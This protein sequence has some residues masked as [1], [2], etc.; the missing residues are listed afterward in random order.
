M[1]ALKDESE[2]VVQYE[3]DPDLHDTEQAP[4]TEAGGVAAFLR[5][6]VLPYYPDG[7]VRAGDRQDRLRDQL[8]PLLLPTPAT[9]PAGGDQG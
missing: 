5:R 9:A 3:P 8:H 4:L 6:E 1:K 7:L 2:R